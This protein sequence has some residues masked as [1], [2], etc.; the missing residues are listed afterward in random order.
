VVYINNPLTVIEQREILGKNFRIYGSIEEPFFLAKDV[1]AWIEYDTSKVSRLVNAID[2]EE[3][4][5]RHSVSTLGGYQ[6]LWFVT[7]D[8]LYEILMQSKKPI[9]KVFKRKIKEI[10]KT[11]RKTG[12]YATPEFQLMQLMNAKQDHMEKLLI[13]SGII[14]TNVNPRYIF[15][16]LNVR[17]KIATGDD[18]IRGLYD[19]IGNYFGIPVPYRANI[20]VTVKD[21]ILAKF[22]LDEIQEFVLGIEAGVITKS[23][24]GYW[25]NLNGFGGNNIEWNK[26]LAYFGHQCVY[27]G[28]VDKALIP[29]HIVCQSYLSQS[30]PESVDLIGNIVCSCGSCNKAKNKSN[31]DE[32]YP[33][34]LQFTQQR[35]NKIHKH[36]TKYKLAM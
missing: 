9:A 7:E 27:C 2:E 19:A 36:Q 29:E 26:V 35:L 8:G 25:I 31:V 24:R 32:W 18:N 30:S 34:H 21:W 6:E 16:R 20:N 28:D 13:D 3:D 17:Y 5:V 4:K 15:D 14:R 11:I 1:A 23:F 12:H 22:D 33:T 10:L